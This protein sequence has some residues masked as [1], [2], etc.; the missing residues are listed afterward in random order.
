MPI[1]IYG[2]CGNHTCEK[3]KRDECYDMMEQNYKFYL[4]FENSICNDY[5]TEKLFSILQKN[6]VPIVYGGVNYD[7]IAPPHSVI[8]VTKYKTVKEL[9]NYLKFLDKNPEEY[10]KYFAWKKN[11]IID[12]SHKST[13]CQLCE[14]LNQPRETQFYEDIVGWLNAPGLCKTGKKLPPIVFS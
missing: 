8:D 9:A 13:L 1:D 7:V 4:S 5:V 6:V 10:L 3:E 12:T 11:Y 2:K 14:K